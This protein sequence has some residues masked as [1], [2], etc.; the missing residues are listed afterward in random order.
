M[1]HEVYQT[2]V[3]PLI[4]EVTDGYNCTVFAYGQVMHA[5]LCNHAHSN[6]INY[7]LLHIDRNWQDLHYGWRG[8]VTP[9][10]AI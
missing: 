5:Y 6:L 7:R 8:T 10:V 9:F 4:Q 2:V 1:Q 3:A